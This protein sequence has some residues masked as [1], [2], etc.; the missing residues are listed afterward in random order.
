MG[1]HI[2]DKTKQS[3]GWG[4]INDREQDYHAYIT[5]PEVSSIGLSCLIVDYKT[6]RIVHTLSKG[7]TKVFYALRWNDNVLEIK[8]QVP[9]DLNETNEIAEHLNLRPSHDGNKPMSTDFL[10]TDV[11]GRQ[12]AINVKPN[13]MSLNKRTLN[14]QEIEKTYWN[15]HSIEWLQIFGDEISSTYAMN[16]ID[17]TQYY[18]KSRVF[19]LYSRI[20]H[21]I[22]IKAIQVNL[23]DFI[24]YEALINIYKRCADEDKFIKY[25]NSFPKHVDKSKILMINDH[26]SPLY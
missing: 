15:N 25:I 3:R 2:S 18:D 13:A 16:L 14:K 8:D 19:D 4:N 23:Y 17:V 20:K 9:L 1:R 7:E 26:D 12:I 6:G 21:L 22:A 5:V 10:I 11:L 24:N